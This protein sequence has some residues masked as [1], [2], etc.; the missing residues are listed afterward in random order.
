[1]KERPLI[2]PSELQQL[3]CKGN[4]GNAIVTIF[5]YYPIRSQ[6]TPSYVSI[7]FENSKKVQK[8]RTGR[9]CGEKAAFYDVHIRNEL[10]MNK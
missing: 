8:M 3:N 7:Y 1:M 4:M 2:Y 5:G 6:F 10:M 9:Y